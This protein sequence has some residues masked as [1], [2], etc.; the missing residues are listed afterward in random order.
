MFSNSSNARYRTTHCFSSISSFS[1]LIKYTK[2]EVLVSQGLTAE[3]RVFSSLASVYDICVLFVFQIHLHLKACFFL[4]TQT[5]AALPLFNVSCRRMHFFSHILHAGMF[6]SSYLQKISGYCLGFPAVPL[7]HIPLLAMS[8]LLQ[9]SLPACLPAWPT[10]FS[11]AGGC[12]AAETRPQLPQ[13][14]QGKA[15]SSHL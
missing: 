13:V 12:S 14:A 3:K 10:A 2:E 4:G 5:V 9:H 15:F 7:L 6:L 1:Y 11:H 8:V